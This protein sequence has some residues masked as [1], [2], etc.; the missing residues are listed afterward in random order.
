MEAKVSNNCITIINSY[1]MNNK[2]RMK[3]YLGCLKVMYPKCEVFKRSD[4]SLI[5]EWRAHNLL[6]K[7]GL[8]RSHT[9]D[10]DLEYPIERKYEIIW[11]ILGI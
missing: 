8:Y 6:Y 4:K 11:N 3:E 1:T 7:L 10:V 9:K 2:E 5:R